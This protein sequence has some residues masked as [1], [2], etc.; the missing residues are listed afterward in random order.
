M[1]G[2]LNIV[3]AKLRVRPYSRATQFDHYSDTGTSKLRQP[4][5]FHFVLR[6]LGCLAQ[7]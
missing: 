3:A 4:Q 5:T 2:D 6:S 1:I 7:G